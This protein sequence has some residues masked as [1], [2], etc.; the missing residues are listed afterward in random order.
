MLKIK[1]LLF[2]PLVLRALFVVA[3][4]IKPASFIFWI[5]KLMADHPEWHRSR[6]SQE[7][8]AGPAFKLD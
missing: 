7:I 3:L 5:C 2:T 8:C 4:G 6:L 1:K